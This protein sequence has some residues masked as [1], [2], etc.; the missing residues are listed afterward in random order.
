MAANDDDQINLDISVL[1]QPSADRVAVRLKDFGCVWI[2]REEVEPTA[3]LVSNQKGPG[4]ICMDH[5]NQKCRSGVRCV[6]FHI[7]PYVL[8]TLYRKLLSAAVCN[9]CLVHGDIAS[10]V[11]EY[12]NILQR[13]AIELIGDTDTPRIFIAPEFVAFTSHWCIMKDMPTFHPLTVRANRVCRLHQERRCNWGS[14][15]GNA[16]V[17]RLVWRMRQVLLDKH[18]GGPVCTGLAYLITLSASKTLT[19]SSGAGIQFQA[20]LTTPDNSSLLPQVLD[21]LHHQSHMEWINAEIL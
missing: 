12:S 11:L 4:M 1:F 10:R 6:R 20:L 19:V 7:N 18:R 21:R 3:A 15:C 9:C 16:H 5:Q 2:P 17:C 13:S 8:S 14:S